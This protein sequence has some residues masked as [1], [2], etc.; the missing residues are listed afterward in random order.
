LRVQEE[1][2][3]LNLPGA[4]GISLALALIAILVLILMT[5]LRPKEG[6]A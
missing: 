1:Y 2:E 3:N 5:T 4:Y 6:T